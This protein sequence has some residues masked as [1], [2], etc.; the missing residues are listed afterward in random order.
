MTQ[1]NW[2]AVQLNIVQKLSSTVLLSPQLLFTTSSNL[3]QMIIYADIIIL[4][5]QTPVITQIAS[6]IPNKKN[7][8]P[9]Y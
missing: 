7:I 4:S 3:C 9:L 8:L 1:H 6:I 5:Q 2:A